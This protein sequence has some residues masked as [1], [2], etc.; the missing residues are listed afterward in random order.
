MVYHSVLACAHSTT[1]PHFMLTVLI[2]LVQ[3]HSFRDLFWSFVRSVLEYCSAVWR[4]AYD[5]HLK[6]L[7]RVVSGAGFSAGGVI[8]PNHAHRRSVAV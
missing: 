1:Q 5:S 7:D 2:K 4:S 3:S 6:L 8:E